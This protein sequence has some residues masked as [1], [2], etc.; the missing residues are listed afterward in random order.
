[1][2]ENVKRYTPDIKTGLTDS[3]IK[4]RIER[5]EYNKESN[6]KS[7][8]ISLILRDNVCTIFNLVNFILAVAVF[9]VGSYKN[10][11]FM[12]IIIINSLIGTFQEIRA[13]RTID[14]LSIVNQQKIKAVRNGKE[15]EIGINE[16]VLD[17]V[18]YLKQG[19]Q[20]PTDC[21]IAQGSCEVNE[22]LLTGESDAV[23]KEKDSRLISGS[24]LVSGSCVVIAEKVGDENYAA[25]IS[26][27]AKYVKKVDSQILNTLNFI[28]K[29]MSIV[30]IP[31]G[32]LLFWRQF[33][34]T[35][36]ADIS[37]AVVKSVAALIGMIPEGLM[38]LTSTVM[39][40]GV[41]R[42][43]RRKVL[44]QEMYCIEALA[45][46]DVLCLDKTG[47]ITEG[48]M[49]VMDY[50]SVNPNENLENLL[51]AFANCSKD[52]N[53]TIN[54][55]KERY[56]GKNTT[57]RADH[58]VAFSSEK[59]WSGINF[60]ADGTYILGAEEFVFGGK[61]KEIDELTKDVPMG[62][63]VL[64]IGF[65]ENDFKDRELPDDIRPIG[66]VVFKDKIRKEAPA[67]LEYFD[68]QGV[69]LKVISGDNVHTVAAIAKEA[70]LKNA[71]RIVDA[72]TLKT[73]EDVYNAVEK[74]SVFGRVTP[75]QKLQMVNALKK[76]GHTV[77]MTGDGVNDVLALK[78]ADCSVAMA[79][80]SDAA[81]C[82]SQLVLLD[83]NFASMP[84]VVAEGRR[85]INNIQ[86]SASL[87]L[88]KTIY[89]TLLAVIFVFIGQ[90]Y[91]F[92]PI[93]MT[94]ISTFCIGFPSFVLALEPNESRITGNFLLN[95]LKRAIP[96]GVTITSLVVFV[97]IA[98][99]LMRLDPTFISTLAVAVTAFTGLMVIFKTSLPFNLIRTAMFTIC[100][101]GVV[102]G[103]C[104]SKKVIYDIMHIDNLFGM[105]DMSFEFLIGFVVFAAVAVGIFALV[106]RITNKIEVPDN[107]ELKLPKLHISTLI[108]KLKR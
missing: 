88:V 32:L 53:P 100:I 62:Y 3:Q 60:G 23:F 13:K 8:P 2:S 11:L 14:K 26:N 92:M 56:C 59:K 66:V 64:S 80:G 12:V 76:H 96:G 48:C 102:F 63:R 54:A 1:M 20:V 18:F 17:E 52:S 87:F 65:S 34:A 27:G 33:M 77:A 29:L 107:N 45:R 73:E 94:L 30:I 10:M 57:L 44:V 15:C 35:D 75:T 37:S 71:D 47:T 5:G 46:V 82:V 21:I 61:C 50:K 86:R 36:Y 93:Q 97:T 69:D 90:L 74:Y 70:G 24:F 106:S 84:R 85:S 81:R 7:K 55:V 40:I 104:F 39:A 91:P 79:S 43:S 72:T 25:S 99:N 19:Q 68:K 105:A 51:I 101:A 41:I 4:E 78:E 9:L 98:G 31:V 58:C 16:I 49:E 103:V 42:L 89:S 38:L 6:L 108:N 22:S 83:S 95:I 67:T 28:I